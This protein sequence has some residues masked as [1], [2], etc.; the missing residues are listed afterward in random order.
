VSTLMDVGTGALTAI[1]QLGQGQTASPEDGALIL[2][3][4]NLLLDQWSTQRLF[5]Y[6]VGIRQH[7]LNSSIP[8]YTLGPSGAMSGTRP[9]F[10][11]S[12]QVNV[13]GSSIWLPVNVL[14]KSKW[15]AIINKNAIADV[16]TDMYPAP[17][18]PNWTI[19]VN[20]A[21]I[22]AAQ[23]RFGV[24]EAFTQ[25]ISLFDTILFP[26]AYQEFLES[27]LAIMLAPYYDQQVPQGLLARQQK[28][29]LAVMKINA[30]GLGGSLGAT[31]LLQSPNTGQPISP[32]GSQGGGQ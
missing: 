31:Q 25:F 13:P 17:D 11:E 29:E 20:P 7:S 2:R 26:P 4:S 24:W 18:Y 5:L 23:I 10:I 28:A 30:Q 16:P 12:C 19:Y 21:P 1:G 15:D 9:S 8:S 14:D 22:L 32:G 6:V 3:N 27:S